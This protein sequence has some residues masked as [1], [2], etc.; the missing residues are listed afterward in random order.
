MIFSEKNTP[1]SDLANQMFIAMRHLPPKSIEINEKDFMANFKI[2][3][4]TRAQ[5]KEFNEITK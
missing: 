4:E 1:P 3:K 5:R 2:Y